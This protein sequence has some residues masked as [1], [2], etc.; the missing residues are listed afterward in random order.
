M[1]TARFLVVTGLLVALGGLV[2]ASSPAGA[3]GGNLSL[4]SGTGI[5]YPQDI[6]SGPD[7]A[8]WFTNDGNDS[9]GRITTGGAV[10]NYRLSPPSPSG[11]TAGSDGDALWF[12]ETLQATP[13]VGSPPPG[14]CHHLQRHRCQTPLRHH[15]RAPDGSLWFTNQGND[16]IGRITTAGVVSNDKGA[17]IDGPNDI[18]DRPRRGAVVHQRHATTRSAG[19]PRL[20]ERSRDFSGAGIDQPYDITTGPDG[21]HV[22]HQPRQQLDR[23]DHHRRG[24][25]SNYTDAGIDV[26]PWPSPPVP[27]ARCGSPTGNSMAAPSVASP[28]TGVVSIEFGGDRVDQA[29]RIID[30]AGRRRACG[31]PTT[32][33]TPSDASPPPAWSPMSAEARRRPAGGFITAGP[34]GALWFTDLSQPT[35]SVGSPPPAWS[36]TSP[37]PAS[38]TPSAI[39]TGPDGAL[40]FINGTSIGRITTGGVVTDYTGAI[41]AHAITTGP[42][43]ALWFTNGIAGGGSIGRITTAGV[44]LELHRGS[45]QPS[46]IT[47][48]PDGA[49]WFTNSGQRL[50]RPD[51]HGRGGLR[52]TPGR[53]STSPRTPSPPVPTGR[54]GSPMSATDSIGRITTDG[55]V[56]EFHRGRDRRSRT[57]SPP[58][59][60][61]RC[62]SPT[63]VTTPSGAS[64]RPGSFRPT[65]A[66]GSTR[67]TASPPGPTGPCGSRTKATT[68]SGGSPPPGSSPGSARWA[69][70]D[71]SP[72]PPDPTGPCGSPVSATAPSAASSPS[73]GP[74]EGPYRAASIPARS[75]ATKAGRPGGDPP[76]R[77]VAAPEPNRPP[78]RR[79]RQQTSAA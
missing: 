50:D 9:I 70:I 47:T 14:S 52:I 22:V 60:T 12:T 7:G 72:S 56:S 15:R 71:P 66:G 75:S 17:A 59:P 33:T 10:S 2:A 62:G 29:N 78:P 61:G 55:V 54:C 24:G 58:V 35:P 74:A 34:D 21:A 64:P 44:G 1:R 16:S 73:P 57:P 45:D 3:S 32:A 26:S 46:A 65:P 69:S 51:H 18:A 23:P 41:V 40:W 8:L 39:T 43:G 48:G 5:L 37:H 42:D 77:A 4:F 27:T 36:P 19:S 20:E 13:S 30:R 67:P 63:T 79:P 31:S 76:R 53:E 38:A 11:I 6:T 49:L 68:P 25:D 28:P